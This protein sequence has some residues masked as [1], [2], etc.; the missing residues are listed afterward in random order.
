MAL[1]ILAVSGCTQPAPISIAA[2][3]PLVPPT[4]SE[5]GVNPHNSESMQKGMVMRNNGLSPSTRFSTE[6][7]GVPQTG[8]AQGVNPHDSM[9]M[10]P[11]MAMTPDR[12]APMTYSPTNVP[13]TGSAQGVNTPYAVPPQDAP[14]PY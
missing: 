4:G 6:P 8:S 3:A 7:S 2:D 11:G 13:R 12:T 14:K 1:S 9:P 10:R 5:S